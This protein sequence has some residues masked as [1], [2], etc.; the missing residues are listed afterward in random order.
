MSI[1][2]LVALFLLFFF[3][4]GEIFYPNTIREG[5][6]T[7]VPALSSKSSFFSSFVPKR[8]DVGIDL[9]E[10]SYQQDG[11]YFRGYAD[12]Q[13]I[14]VEQD[15]CRMVI[16]KTN[17]EEFFAC[18]LA[19]TDNLAST[20]YRTPSVKQGLRLSRDDYMNKG[21]YCRILK[22]K[23]GSWQAQ[24]NKPL[25]TEFDASLQLDGAP[26]SEIELLLTFYRGCM[27]W[28][29][30][31]DYMEDYVKNV[32]VYKKGDIVIEE[33]PPSP[34]VTR[35]LPFNG[36][37]QFLRIADNQDLELGA[38]VK[39]RSMRAVMVWVYFDEF[40]NNAH[41]FDFGNGAGRD[42]ILLGILG[43]GDQDIN[44]AGILRPPLLC[45]S[46]STVPTGKSGAQP[47][48][49]ESPQEAMKHSKANVDDFTCVG[50]EDVPRRLPPSRVTDKIRQQE[51]GNATL[52]YEIWDAQQRK[53]RITIPSAIPKK[54]WT[55]IC[56]T[57]KSMDS[58]RPDIAVYI[59][60]Q[61]NF[62]QPSGWLPQASY[63]NNN[64]L[65]KS[66]WEN[67]TSQYEN[68]DELFKGSLF[69]FRAY[70]VN[71][72]DD[73]IKKSFTWGKD[74]LGLLD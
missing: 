73:I 31:R 43:K 53:M 65:G 36:I 37:D 44:D 23:D 35:G 64:Y 66:N 52:L 68:K 71:L 59:D 56:I 47:V 58:F 41:I 13:R 16:D 5:F 51:T 21:A 49:E 8:G 45:G 60:G 32:K 9:E 20:K 12:V 67:T 1:G 55:H 46:E 24:C 25:D 63:T 72:S 28:L 19:G 33:Y 74:K 29:R 38:L 42:N 22:Y 14:G 6:E 34:I 7:L 10:E 15:F 30:F 4:A 11:R 48:D 17:D 61:E 39:L 69:D 18:A 70:N 50:F 27:I 26:P 57:A 40:T 54:K 2:I 3:A 62:I